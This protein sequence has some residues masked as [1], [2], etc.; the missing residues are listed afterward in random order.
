MYQLLSR[1][2][3]SRNVKQR[4]VAVAFPTTAHQVYGIQA[5][6]TWRTGFP[7]AVDFSRGYP[8]YDPLAHRWRSLVEADQVDVVF[9]ILGDGQLAAG[10]P[11][12]ERD[13]A[14]LNQWAAGKPLLESGTQPR[15]GHAKLHFNTA[16]IAGGRARETITI[17]R[18]DG[19]LLPLEPMADRSRPS[20]AEMLERLLEQL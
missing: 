8:A 13:L 7:M 1:W 14:L 5:A 6:L 4:F 10:G 12:W 2:V 16:G 11:A 19:V 20:E 9:L 18:P 3:G 17:G 15:V